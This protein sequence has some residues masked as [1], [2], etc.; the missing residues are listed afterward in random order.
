MSFGNGF[1]RASASPEKAI[2]CKER[3]ETRFVVIILGGAIEA[4]ILFVSNAIKKV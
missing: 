2:C 4:M 3:E 1:I